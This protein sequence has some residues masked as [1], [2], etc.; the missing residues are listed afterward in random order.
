MGQIRY[1]K[2]AKGLIRL[3]QLQRFT[4]QFAKLGFFANENFS[5][6]RGN[7]H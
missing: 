2:K 3:M 5:V 7:K 1:E 6:L 4:T